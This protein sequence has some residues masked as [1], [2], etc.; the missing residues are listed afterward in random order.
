VIADTKDEAL[1]QKHLLMLREETLGKLAEAFWG[2]VF[3]ASGIG[4]IPLCRIET[5]HAPGLISSDDTTVLPDFEIVADGHSAYVDSKA[6]T[7]S[8]IYHKRNQ[9][10]HGI[11]RR[12]WEHYLKTGIAF[13][14]QCGLVVLELFRDGPSVTWSGS[15]LVETFKNLG[16]PWQGESTQRHMV[17]WTRKSFVDLDSLE[18]TEIREAAHGRNVP[19]YPLELRE[20]F[21]GLK[22]KQQPLF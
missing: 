9:E 11:N 3:R 1:A 12:V 6:K 19:S 7:Q 10:R 16:E 15:L 4:Y 21:L 20:V 5:D 2:N 22:K 8:I 18:A 14:K 17:Y 13:E